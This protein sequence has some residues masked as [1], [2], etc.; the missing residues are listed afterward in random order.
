[1]HA[2]EEADLAPKM[3]DQSIALASYYLFLLGMVLFELAI[4]VVGLTLQLPPPLAVCA[5]ITGAITILLMMSITA[6]GITG[7]PGITGPPKPARVMLILIGTLL[8][9]NVVVHALA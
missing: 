1:M 8:N 5:G 6:V 2:I 4:L 9:W 3:T 7:I